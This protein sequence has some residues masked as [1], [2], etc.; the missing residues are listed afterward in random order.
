MKVYYFNEVT[1]ELEG[2]GD[3]FIP[4]NGATDIPPPERDYLF[5][6]GEWVAPP[7][8]TLEEL[9]EEKESE[10][11]SAR[12]AEEEQGVIIDGVRYAGDAGNRQALDEAVR[13]A[14]KQGIT[15]YPTWKDSDGV[16]HS[17]H[18]VAKVDEALMAIAANRSA[19]IGKEGLKLQE[20]NNATNKEALEVIT[21]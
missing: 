17:N 8:K 14:E 2:E 19:L 5:K 6:N 15:A 7:A 4:P 21:W 9:K 13:F 18:P 16:F 3:S 11:I 10:I 12:K 20:I 1:G